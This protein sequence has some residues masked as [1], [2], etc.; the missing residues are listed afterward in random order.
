M[1]H[2]DTMERQLYKATHI[3]HPSAVWTRA[4]KA[5]YN[6]LY[7]LWREL[8]SEYTFRYQKHH[9]C[10][11][12]IDVLKRVPNNIPDG[13][14]TEPTPAMPE[15][16]IKEGDSIASYHK[17]YKQDKKRMFS[18]KYREVPSWI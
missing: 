3:N 6:W 5:N 8:M 15:D 12:L 14:F 4:S 16:Y 7:V 13:E 1:T 2:S 9:E 10:E 18:W 11:K 17:Y